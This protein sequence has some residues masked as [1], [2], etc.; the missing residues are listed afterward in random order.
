MYHFEET[1]LGLPREH[2][3]TMMK[4]SGDSIFGGL[5]K[6]KGDTKIRQLLLPNQILSVCLQ[7]IMALAV[8]EAVYQFEH[9][10]LHLSNILVKQTKKSVVRFKL[11][12]TVYS[13]PSYGVKAILIDVTF[14]RLVFGIPNG[15]I[16]SSNL[17]PILKNI[18]SDSSAPD[19]QQV[20]YKTMYQLVGDNWDRWYP[21]TNLIWLHYFFQEVSSANVFGSNAHSFLSVEAKRTKSILKVFIGMTQ[22]ML[23]QIG[24][25]KHNHQQKNLSK[26]VEKILENLPN[27][28]LVVED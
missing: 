6:I 24:K 5:F 20:A 16:F 26:L 9:R 22:K 23:G 10:D 8:A 25:Q 3:V 15:Q 13:V 12:S 1:G 11:R 7:V 2:L 21:A 17:S 28:G 19:L 27:C 18:K 14:S 4:F